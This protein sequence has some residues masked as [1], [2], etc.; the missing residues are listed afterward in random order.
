MS[1]SEVKR[2]P[3]SGELVTSM[4]PPIISHSGG[5]IARPRP[6]P[7]VFARGGESTWPEGLEEQPEAVGRDADARSLTE[8]IEQEVPGVGPRVGGEATRSR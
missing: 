1:R 3:W 6:V 7:A 4:L 2:E 5:C 8:K